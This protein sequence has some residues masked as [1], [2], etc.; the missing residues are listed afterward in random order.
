MVCTHM[1]TR[2]YRGKAFT[3]HALQPYYC[4]GVSMEADV[5]EFSRQCLLHCM[6]IKACELK[7]RPLRQVV[8]D[9]SIDEV[10]HILNSSTSGLAGRW[11]RRAWARRHYCNPSS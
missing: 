1:S 8:H 6:D 11:T 9:S 10:L 2:G 3:M 7:P 5:G 4:V